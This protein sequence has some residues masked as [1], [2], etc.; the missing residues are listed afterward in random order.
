MQEDFASSISHEI[1]TP[2]GFIKGYAS[3]LLRED[4]QW[5][6]ATER[7]FLSIIEDEADRLSQLMENMLESAILRSKTAQFKF[8]P[9][10]IDALVRDVAARVQAHRQDL[11]IHLNFERVPAV[12][13][14]GVRLSQVFENL[15]GNAL[16]YAPGSPITVAMTNDRKKLRIVF[17]DHG[18]GIP[19]EYLPFVFE[20]F[21]RV[22][23]DTS[24]T[25]TGL[26]LY[27]CQQ[28]IKAHHGK[29]WA[30]SELDRGTTFLI[31]LPLPVSV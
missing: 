5:D 17:A 22:P 4:T 13:G 31:E 2:L 19:E 26:G 23:A 20:R 11:E 15:F 24:S 12:L 10:Q 29:I 14:D 7:E 30:E 16:K 18:P 6:K 25:G 28:I 21:Y 27:I 8:H 9:L 1:R 3:S